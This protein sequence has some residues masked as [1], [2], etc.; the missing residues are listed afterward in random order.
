V[1]WWCLLAAAC[2]EP[3]TTRPRLLP[4]SSDWQEAAPAAATAP[5]SVA[6]TAERVLRFDEQGRF[7]RVLVVDEGTERHLRFG[8]VDAVSQSTISLTDPKAVPMD[9]I[10]VAF[11]GVLF[12]D[13]HERGLMVGLGGGTFTALLRRHYPEMTIDVAEVD[14]TV[15]RAAK[16]FFSVQ[17]DE[18][19][20][21]H[22]EDGA[23]FV[24]KTPHQYD[25]A[26]I[27]AYEGNDIP[28]QLYS[29]AFFQSLAKKIAPGGV[30]VLNLSVSDAL[31]HTIERRFRAAFAEVRCARA[32]WDG[33]ELYGRP[34]RGMP[35][36]EAVREQARASTLGTS[37]DLEE[38]AGR[39]GDHCP[40]RGR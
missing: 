11:V 10:R 24:A 33:L 29:P 8:E 3:A 38:V 34:S 6:S 16:E 5:S 1:W 27:D 21:I 4:S 36:A 2:T 40:P 18:R 22:V 12:T 25:I 28:K 9:Y 39:V 23:A 13:R 17:E 35:T 15:V 7:A 37:F 19:F 30:A 32:Q 31:E 14:P 26:L 20:Q